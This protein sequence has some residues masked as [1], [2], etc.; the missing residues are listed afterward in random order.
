MNTERIVTERGHSVRARAE[1]GVVSV[2]ATFSM[3]G[4]WFELTPDEAR[5]LAEQLVNAANTLQIKEAA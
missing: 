2:S 3:A 4:M 5:K 1:F